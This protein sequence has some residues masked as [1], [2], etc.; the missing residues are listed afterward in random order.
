MTSIITQLLEL[1]KKY[2]IS[3]DDVIY[4]IN[5][6]QKFGYL[7]GKSIEQ[8]LH[9]IE[10]YQQWFGLTVDSELGP[11]T[12]TSMRQPRCQ[13]MDVLEAR[14]SKW[15]LTNL[16]YYIKSR[17]TGEITAEQWDQEIADAFSY[18]SEVCPL[19]FTRVNSTNANII[20][21]VSS[22]RGDGL[23]TSGGTLAFAQL[24]PNSNYRGQ[25][26]TVYDSAERWSTTS[27]GGINLSSV[28]CHEGGHLLGLDHTNVRGALMYPTYSPS[29]TKP[30]QNDDIKRI[31]ALYGK[32]DNTP[33][34]TPEP[35]PEPTPTP[36][37]GLTI[38]IEGTITNVEIP[39]YRVYKMG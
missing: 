21:S 20:L 23:G 4:A 15:G 17:D 10:L 12:L 14:N 38:K 19:K 24:P 3:L 11:Q 26:I 39:G 31:Q 9:A 35:T 2:D 7:K 32:P 28:V 27:G 34:P 6:L 18:W 8:I 33:T 29:V 36:T 13:H 25:L 16:T 22:N 5:F 1:F 30:Q 37:N